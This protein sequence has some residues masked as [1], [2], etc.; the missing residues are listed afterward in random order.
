MNPMLSMLLLLHKAIDP[1]VPGG[2]GHSVS[3]KPGSHT[4]TDD[5][6]EVAL[7]LSLSRHPHGGPQHLFV[8]SDKLALRLSLSLQTDKVALSLRL[9]CRAQGVPFR[10]GLHLSPLQ[11]ISRSTV[12]NTLSHLT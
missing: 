4:G 8:P 9:S 5:L 10:E 6:H 3:A 7:N 2:G 12:S 1:V 11:Q